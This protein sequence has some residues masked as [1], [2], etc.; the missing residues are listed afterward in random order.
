MW[1]CVLIIPA[2]DR[3]RWVDLYEFEARL[4][5][6]KFHG[7]HSGLYIETLPQNKT[8]NQR[9]LKLKIKIPKVHWEHRVPI[10]LRKVHDRK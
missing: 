5:Y 7:G 1:R 3:Q 6:R 8:T 4:S 10:L 2:L 9:K